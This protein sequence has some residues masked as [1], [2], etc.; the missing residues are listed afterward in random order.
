[1]TTSTII[2]LG[3]YVIDPGSHHF[4][5]DPDQRIPTNPGPPPTPIPAV[6]QVTAWPTYLNTADGGVGGVA[7][8]ENVKTQFAVAPP[9]SNPNEPMYRIHWDVVNESNEKMRVILRMV[10]T[11]P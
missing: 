10:V 6:V 11:S 9:G 3:S 8:V 1:M 2:E 7:R 4:H 5:F